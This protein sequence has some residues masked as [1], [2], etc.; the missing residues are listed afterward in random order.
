M[1]DRNN[2]VR[3]LVKDIN[4]INIIYEINANISKEKDLEGIGYVKDY[5]TKEILLVNFNN[6]KIISSHIFDDIS[7]FMIKNVFNIY[8]NNY[9]L[10]NKKM[11]KNDV[12]QKLLNYDKKKEYNKIKS[13][14]TDLE[15]LIKTLSFTIYMAFERKNKD[16]FKDPNTIYK[17]IIQR[18]RNNFMENIAI[19]QIVK[20]I[21]KNFSLT[22]KKV[23]DENNLKRYLKNRINCLIFFAISNKEWNNYIKY[24]K[25]HK[26]EN[27]SK[28]E[29]LEPTNNNIENPNNIEGHIVI[30]SDIDKE[31]NYTFKL[32]EK[33]YKNI[34]VFKVKKDCL[35]NHSFFVIHFFEELLTEKK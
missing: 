6:K 18:Y 23:N 29:I 15:S 8:D 4:N 13:F 25:E 14:D 34:G 28:K 11:N 20:D 2:P 17:S 12:K 35:K 26:L 3:I 9:E 1:I 27:M 5:R 31:G 24:S 19:E 7:K 32:Y 16:I 22:Y 21:L 33:E 10:N 30:L